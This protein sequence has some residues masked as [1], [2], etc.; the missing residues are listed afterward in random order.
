M[1][2]A[3]LAPLQP[4]AFSLRTKDFDELAQGIPGWDAVF[5]QVGPGSFR[6][7]F[8]FLRLGAMNFC[9]ISGNCE[10]LARGAH[11]PGTFGF[12]VPTLQ[13]RTTVVSGRPLQ[14]GQVILLGPRDVLDQT[15]CT[16]YQSV[17]V[18]VDAAAFLAAMGALTRRDAQADL[19]CR[20]CLSPSSQAT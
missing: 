11:R 20:S 12:G 1:A 9:R 8:D 19:A 3:V 7:E 15:T 5:S 17:F 4:V 14:E 18:E 16:D 10:I 13:Q 2:P 6:G